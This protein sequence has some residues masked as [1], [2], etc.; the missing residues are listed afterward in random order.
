MT[1]IACRL[2]WLQVVGKVSLSLWHRKIA[3]DPPT[4]KMLDAK[5]KKIDTTEVLVC[6]GNT[7]L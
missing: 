5:V 7:L 1:T 2:I 3:G 4:V 6:F